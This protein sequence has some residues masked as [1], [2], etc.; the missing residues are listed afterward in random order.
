MPYKEVI[1]G[2]YN[3]KLTNFDKLIL[4]KAFRVEMINLSLTEFII[5]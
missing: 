4:I 2:E 3:D 1:P 5:R